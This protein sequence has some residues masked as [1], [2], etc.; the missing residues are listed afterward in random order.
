MAT[1]AATHHRDVSPW[2]PGPVVTSGRHQNKRIFYTSDNI[3]PV[4]Q[5]FYF[6]SW[7]SCRFLKNISLLV[8]SRLSRFY[9]QVIPPIPA[10]KFHYLPVCVSYI[11]APC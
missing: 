11:H 9:K 5:S 8:I 7:L 3:T 1:S 4:H 2:L 6:F 10:H